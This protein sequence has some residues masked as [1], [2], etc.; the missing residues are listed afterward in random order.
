MLRVGDDLVVSSD[1]V[2]GVFSSIES[3]CQLLEVLRKGGAS[4]ITCGWAKA[5]VLG[6]FM[7]SEVSIEYSYCCE[8]G[9]TF[10]TKHSQIMEHR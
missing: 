8:G 2:E 4:S 9:R 10:T 6:L 5:A 7:L 3:R 1:V